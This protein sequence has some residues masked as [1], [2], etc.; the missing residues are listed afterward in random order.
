LL[1]LRD[2]LRRLVDRF[3]RLLLRLRDLDLDFLLLV[4]RFLLDRLVD[5]FR[6]RDFLRLRDL[7]LDRL[8]VRECRRLDDPLSFDDNSPKAGSMTAEI[9]L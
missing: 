6:L 2:F 3:L 1:R 4:E 5:R 8:R 7:S 9:W